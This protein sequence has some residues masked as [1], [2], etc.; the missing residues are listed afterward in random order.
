MY[1]PRRRPYD[2]DIGRS[3]PYARHPSVADAAPS[4]V[5]GCQTIAYR[6]GGRGTGAIATKGTGGP[7]RRNDDGEEEGGGGGGA[8]VGTGGPATTVVRISETEPQ[9]KGATASA[10][11]K[12]AKLE[13]GV[14]VLVPPFVS[15][16]EEI[17]VDPSEN[18]Y[19][20]RAKKE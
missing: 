14:T 13:N 9:V 2:P 11:Y 4:V 5:P 20:E 8:G 19:L 17:I 10:S 7:T 3:S 1:P 6:T 12:P 15:E 16:G 18:R